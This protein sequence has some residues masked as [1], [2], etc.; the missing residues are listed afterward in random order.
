[1]GVSGSFWSGHMNKSQTD[2]HTYQFQF[3]ECQRQ[4][5]FQMLLETKQK[6]IQNKHLTQCNMQNSWLVLLYFAWFKFDARP[7]LNF[8]FEPVQ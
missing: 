5:F 3:G 2:A 4:T 1:M 7:K 8:R 6:P